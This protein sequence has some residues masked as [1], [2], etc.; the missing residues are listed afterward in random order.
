M[1]SDDYVIGKRMCEDMTAEAFASD[2]PKV[3]GRTVEI[4]GG[5][6]PPDVIALID[7]IETG[8]ELTAI[9]AAS[10]EDIV[11]E[12]HRLATQKHE[13]YDRRG[14]FGA[15]R[16]YQAMATYPALWDVWE[17]VDGMYDPS[18]FD[19]F[20]FSE[21]WLMDDGMKYTSRRDP[22]APADFF[23][24]A[25]SDQGGFWELGRK[26]RPPYWHLHVDY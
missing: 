21:I 17:E 3:T 26:R 11:L 7:G 20:G 13:K 4:V 15:R 19:G 2:F 12:M 14:L 16:M 23:C 22:R 6:D 8:V 25:P 9:M 5:D 10:A 24:F 1:S 18:D